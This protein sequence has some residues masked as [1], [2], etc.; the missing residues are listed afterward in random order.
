MMIDRRI[1][2]LRIRAECSPTRAPAAGHVLDVFERLAA[3]EKS[4]GAGSQIR[5]G[6]SLLR[7]FED[8]DGLRIKEPD[9]GRWP[10]QAWI[11]TIDVTL[12][13]L[14]AQTSLLRH[15]GIEGEDAFFDQKIIVAQDAL[16]Q[17]AVFLKR[18]HAF[19]PDDSGWLLAAVADPEAL[20]RGPLEAVFIA[21]L[22]SRRAALLQA[23]T[24]PAG[25][26]ATFAGG[27]LEQVFDAGGT[28]RLDSQGRTT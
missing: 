9:F 8:G 7:L 4:V 19:S 28:A 26:I 17:S 5:F 16:S 22:V 18:G 23:L 21:N 24:L 6:W 20:C 27:L 2:G 14:A 10:R 3:S 15:L 11:D 25:F 1:H 12:D 13:V